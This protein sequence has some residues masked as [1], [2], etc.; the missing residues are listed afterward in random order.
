MRPAVFIPTPLLAAAACAA[1]AALGAAEPLDYNRDIRPILSDKCF[2]CHGPDAAAREAKLRL[3]V[4]AEALAERRSGAIPIVPGKPDLSEV[5]QRIES[6]F[7]N[8]RMSPADSNVTLVAAEI[9]TLRRWIAE[10]AEH[11][12]HWS[13]S[14]PKRTALPGIQNRKSD[15]ENP[16]PH[17]TPCI[18]QRARRPAHR[19]HSS[20]QVLGSVTAVR[21]SVRSVKKDFLQNSVIAAA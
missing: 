11:R 4:R 18:S 9:T 1:T 16:A 13:F 12:P 2:K 21:T 10:G 20:D 7:A 8:E 5:V 6:R 14:T 15:L 17:L 19:S 3:D